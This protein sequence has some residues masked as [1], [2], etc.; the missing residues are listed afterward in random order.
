[1]VAD[2]VGTDPVANEIA[3]LQAE[4]LRLRQQVDG[5]RALA[6]P[7]LDYYHTDEEQVEK[8]L[9]AC[10]TLE[11]WEKFEE[12]A[13]HFKMRALR[14]VDSVE[15]FLTA[16]KD[17]EREYTLFRKDF[18]KIVERMV[19]LCFV[20]APGGTDYI[21]RVIEH[22][23]LPLP[24]FDAKTNRYDIILT[25]IEKLKET[26]HYNSLKQLYVR[27][28]A[29]LGKLNKEL[30]TIA[31]NLGR[32]LVNLPNDALMFSEDKVPLEQA[33]LHFTLTAKTRPEKYPTP[34][35]Q[36]EANKLLFMRMYKEYVAF[37][38]LLRNASN[39]RSSS[40]SIFEKADAELRH[41]EIIFARIHAEYDSIR[42]QLRRLIDTVRRLEQEQGLR[43]PYRKEYIALVKQLRDILVSLQRSFEHIVPALN[44]FSEKKDQPS[45][46]ALLTTLYPSRPEACVLHDYYS[47]LYAINQTLHAKNRAWYTYAV[48][49]HYPAKNVE[50]FHAFMDE[51][52][53]QLSGLVQ[54]LHELYIVFEGKR[55]FHSLVSIATQNNNNQ[56][57]IN[58]IAIAGR[59]I[60]DLTARTRT[61]LT[62]YQHFLRVL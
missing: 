52:L 43:E 11:D 55:D 31:K 42:I 4:V 21:V 47:A 2:P 8:M 40:L 48:Q 16:Q 9:K 29:P 32:V 26:S 39:H 51:F 54:L 33:T 37:A 17:G 20:I 36:L 50:I 35:G 28:V 61:D 62:S 10:Q 38:D 34:D 45:A 41:D 7:S 24:S 58:C 12:F 1:M 19:R 30:E 15:H 60:K 23:K 13:N 59:G 18:K 53:Q 14:E 46:F 5:L 57:T 6:L 3:A 49:H 22:N 27:A 44:R 56:S 25:H